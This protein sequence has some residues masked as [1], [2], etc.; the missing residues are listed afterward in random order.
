MSRMDD[1][2]FTYEVE[3]SGL[4]NIPCDL[5]EED[6]SKQQMTHES[7]DDMEYDLSNAEFTEWLASKFYNHKTMDHYTKNALWIYWAR[8]DDEV[9]L[10]DEES[11]NSD[12]EDEVEFNYLLQIDPDVLT[13]DIDGFKTY[14]EYKDDWIYEWNKDIQWVHEKPWT[15]NGVWKEPTP[16]KHYCEPFNYKNGCSEWPT[17]S[18]KDDGYCWRRWDNFENT[19]R[20][21]EEREYEMEHE[22]NDKHELFDDHERLVCNI[23]RFKMIKYSFSEYEEYVAIKENKFDDLTSTSEEACRVYQEI[24]RSMDEG[25]VDFLYGD[26]TG[27]EIDEVGKE[28]IKAWDQQVVLEHEQSDVRRTSTSEASAMTQL[29]IKKLVANSV[30]TALEAQAANMVNTDKTT[31]PREAHVVRQCS[32]NVT[33]PNWVTEEK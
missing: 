32:Y 26:L 27:K 9:E 33:P 28:P 3:I 14:E 11:S 16:V 22:D 23:R 25:W 20:D 13:K 2:L 8:G 29:A 7:S 17:C 4:A 18:W 30:S 6:D 19:N 1:D 31:R 12:D 15:D 24:F 10:T 5:N 21:H